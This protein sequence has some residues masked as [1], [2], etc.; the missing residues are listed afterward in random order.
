MFFRTDIE[1][2]GRN[3]LVYDRL[4]EAL[5][6]VDEP[7]EIE[8]GAFGFKATLIAEGEKV[9]AFRKALKPPAKPP[10]NEETYPSVHL[11][12]NE[13]LRD[14]LEDLLG[15]KSLYIVQVDD[16]L[17]IRGSA[18]ART[19]DQVMQDHRQAADSLTHANK[20]FSQLEMGE[21]V[22]LHGAT[23]CSGSGGGTGG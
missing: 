12:S 11:R 23:G 1:K 3:S 2:T 21:A 13:Y 8:I 4:L 9:S 5:A 19:F 22:V 14:L 18:F 20:V 15:C 10:I 17:T 6:V 7:V 16:Q